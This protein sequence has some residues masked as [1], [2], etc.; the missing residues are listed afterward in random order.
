VIHTTS[1][2]RAAPLGAWIRLAIGLTLFGLGIAVMIRSNLGLGPWDML[3]QGIFIQTGLSIGRAS[4]V[5]GLAIFVALWP[6]GLRPGPGSVANM[7]LIG[8]VIDLALPHIADASS[9]FRGLGY[10][11]AGIAMT[12][13]GTGLYVSAHMGAGPRDSLMLTLRQR[14]GWPVRRVRLLIETVVLLLGWSMGGT[15]GLGTLLFAFLIGPAVQWSLQFCDPHDLA[16][17]TGTTNEAT[18]NES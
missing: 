9:I 5:I 17:H 16:S 8:L 12:G 14:T 3:H 11:L 4:M 2:R 15:L 6:L 10:H 7:L 18:L 13:F 1:L